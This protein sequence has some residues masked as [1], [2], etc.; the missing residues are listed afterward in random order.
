M[1]GT[2]N[3]VEGSKML[4]QGELNQKIIEKDTEIKN[5]A[6]MIVSLEEKVKQN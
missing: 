5:L 6:H 1:K 3:S 2:K 4:D